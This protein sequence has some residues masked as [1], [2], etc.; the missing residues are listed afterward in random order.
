M[1]PEP[2]FTRTGGTVIL[3]TDFCG[4]VDDVA[5]LAL[6]CG[7]S[8]RHAGAF[9]IGGVSCN[10]VSPFTAPAVKAVLAPFGLQDVPVGVTDDPPPPSG[11][12]SSYLAALA[13]TWRGAEGGRFVEASL[14]CMTTADVSSGR[15][16]PTALPHPATACNARELYRRVFAEAADGS[17]DVISIGFFNTLDEVLAKDPALFRRKVRAVWAMAGGFARC[18]GYAETNVRERPEASRRFLDAW[19]GPIVFVGFESGEKVITDLS[20]LPPECVA[21]PLVEAFRRYCGPSMKRPSWDPVT[22]DFAIHGENE[23]YEISEP[24]HVRVAPDLSTP[25]TPDPAGNARVLRL[26]AP[27]ERVSARITALLREFLQ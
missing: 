17:V 22:V 15:G 10:V 19:D 8:R 6:L 1:T 18:A 20:G 2:L 27:E 3:E 7:E 4:D 26:R 11:N 14:P 9:R 24:G 23:C 16:V 25:F 13:A 12:E 21:H 5:A